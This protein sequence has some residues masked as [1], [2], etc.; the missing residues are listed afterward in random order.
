M[1]RSAPGRRTNLS[2]L[3]LLAVAVVTGALA[4]GIGGRWAGWA[5]VA[6]GIAGLGIAALTPWKTAIAAR[7]IRRRRKRSVASVLFAT[8]VAVALATGI[9]HA[10][11]IATS[12]G[13]VSA[14]QVHVGAA[15]ASLSLAAWHLVARRTWPRRT[16][17]SRR[18]VLRAG[19][20]VGATAAAYVGL[21][22]V[23]HVAGFPG[24]RRRATGSFE[25][26]SLDPGAM[27]V[28]QWLV[29]E[30]PALEP[31]GWWLTI[32]DG[33]GRRSLDYG[34]VSAGR[35]Q[36]RSVLDCTGGWWAEQVWEGVG[37]D[38]LL[39]D[40]DA[41]ASIEVSSVTGYGR[42]FPAADA[43]R[44][45]VATRVGGAVLSAGHGFPARLVVPGRRGF[46]WVKWV[47]RIALSDVPWWWQAPFPVT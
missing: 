17:V 43:G 15:L 11:G 24:A 8:L 22:A 30:V 39:A 18:N 35:R 44:L 23:V 3:G 16:D 45:L 13:P 42:R 28:T 20:V 21:E 37:L 32:V 38:E 4:F 36:L 34:R 25:R 27:P 29:D 9:A 10:T 40:V 19:A 31:D 12:L 5:V 47:D 26:G 46:W 2:L 33:D 1:S 41:A 14:M 6:H 7:G